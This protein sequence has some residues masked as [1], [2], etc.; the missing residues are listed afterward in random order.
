VGYQHLANGNR[1]GAQALLDEG[2]RRL[3]DRRLD[4]LDPGPFARAVR[5]SLAGPLG[6]AAD[7]PKFPRPSR[8][9]HHGIGGR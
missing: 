6:A 7:V 5:D 9:R 2:S 1:T 3:T 8:G 4:E